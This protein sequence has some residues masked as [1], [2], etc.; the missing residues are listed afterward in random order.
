M[1]S[2]RAAAPRCAKRQKRGKHCV[3]AAHALSTCTK[4]RLQQSLPVLRKAEEDGAYFASIALANV[5]HA[6][7]GAAVA[8]CAREEKVHVVQQK[9]IWFNWH[10]AQSRCRRCYS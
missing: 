3:V 10:E 4:Q 5:V 2:T 1:A 8:A 6:K 9:E 7:K